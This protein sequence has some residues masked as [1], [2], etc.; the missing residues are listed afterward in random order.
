MLTQPGGAGEEAGD[1]VAEKV[2]EGLQAVSVAQAALPNLQAALAAGR[3]PSADDLAK[4]TN[5]A[6]SLSEAA[7][8][9]GLDP[10]RATIDDLKAEVAARESSVRLRPVLQRLAHATGPPAAAPGLA[11]LADEAVSLAGKATWSSTDEER[12]LTLAHLV[13]LADMAVGHPDDDQHIL[14]LDADLRRALGQVA[15]PVV[16][17]AVRGRLVLPPTAEPA[18][19]V[20]SMAQGS[21]A[22]PRPVPSA[23]EPEAPLKAPDQRREKPILKPLDREN[24]AVAAVPASPEVIRTLDLT[25]KYPGMDVPAVDRLNLTV[26]A[27]EIFGLLGPN[28]AGKTTTAG[29]LTTRVIP[30]SGKAIVGG[31]DVVAHP[32]L[33]KQ[34][35]GV[36]TQQNTLDR[37]LNVWE[38]LYYHGL[39][40]G[41]SHRASRAAAD[42]L[43]A[44]FHL[45]KWAKS[46]VFALSGGM[47]QRLMVARAILHR[48]RILFMDEPTAGLDPQSRLALWDILSELHAEGQTIL[49]TTHYMEEADQLCDRV[50][51]MDHGKV[52][53]LDTPASLKSSLGAETIVTVSAEGDLDAL[54]GILRRDVEGVTQTQRMDSTVLLHVRGASGVLPQVV[55]SAERGGFA[56]S[57]LSVAEPTLE[58]VFIH[59][60]G[61]E[62]RD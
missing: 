11:T 50:A 60:T 33:A 37:S 62:L 22:S 36:V 26:C 61:K 31:I 23:T 15:A 8:V 1:K 24:P 55:T 56:V 28:G 16:L 3:A 19:N 52:L 53:A 41:M 59:L 48:P 40:F 35:L 45:A 6:P 20:V 46:P 4:L 18:S 14:S 39:Y 30:T 25:K 51:I 34:A 27:G 44:K 57:D 43:L 5:V 42:S 12:A 58:T 21:A 17:A 47:A 13:E 10:G 29:M 2:K 38:N 32:A 54:A 7:G 49:L 9:L